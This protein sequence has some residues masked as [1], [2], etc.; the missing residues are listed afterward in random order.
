MGVFNDLWL[1]RCRPLR[2]KRQLSLS[3]VLFE[4]HGCIGPTSSFL[5]FQ[6][7]FCIN[8]VMLV[9]P[10][11]KNQH[12]FSE[13]SQLLT[14]APWPIPL[15][16]DILSHAN[17]TMW[18]PRPTLWALGLWPLDGSLQTSQRAFKTQSLRLEPRLRNASMPLNGL[19]LPLGAQSAAQ[20]QFQ[21]QN[22]WPCSNTGL[23][24][25]ASVIGEKG[26][27][28]RMKRT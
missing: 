18:H 17:R 11:W 6:S 15:R 1:G 4:G 26:R 8:K 13:L 3:D 19:F 2:L 10:L 14:A 24:K 12:W 9:A 28:S 16:L 25:K 23:L 21:T 22:Q 7:Y 27:S 5:H 20:T